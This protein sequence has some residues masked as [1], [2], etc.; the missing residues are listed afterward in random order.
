[1][2]VNMKVLGRSLLRIDRWPKDAF[3]T[4][5]EYKVSSLQC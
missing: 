2:E 5:V 3:A 1:M 4:D